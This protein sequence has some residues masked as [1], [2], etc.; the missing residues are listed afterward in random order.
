MKCP[1]VY[2][3]IITA[4]LV[5]SGC[6][7]QK[8]DPVADYFWPLKKGQIFTYELEGGGKHIIKLSEVTQESNGNFQVSTEE[9]IVETNLPVNAPMKDHFRIDL[10]NNVIYRSTQSGAAPPK[11]AIY[12]KG[13][14][15]RGVE[16]IFS[17]NF[18]GM[19]VIDESSGTSERKTEGEKGTGVCKIEA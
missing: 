16:W 1:F 17:W 6:S 7:S 15:R 10:K 3:T 18:S 8:G 9:E 11:E 2:M 12:L 13:P 5:T 14:I 19:T 4:V